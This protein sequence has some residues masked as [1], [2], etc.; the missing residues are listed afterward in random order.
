M[1]AIIK[2]PLII[3][4]CKGQLVKAKMEP[5][6]VIELPKKAR[7]CIC[8]KVGTQSLDTQGNIILMRIKKPRLIRH[9]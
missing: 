7:Q 8:Y 1:D 9:R 2:Q 3:S 5:V 6:I 4:Q